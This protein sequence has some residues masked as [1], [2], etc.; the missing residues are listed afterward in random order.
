MGKYNEDERTVTISDDNNPDWANTVTFEQRLQYLCNY[1]EQ[2]HLMI[3]G[4]INV[5]SR[6]NAT[7]ERLQEMEQL[8]DDLFYALNPERRTK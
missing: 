2:L 8:S 6:S 7:L 5:N 3:G 4:M 1:A